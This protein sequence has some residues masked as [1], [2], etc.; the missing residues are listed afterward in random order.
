MR[1]FHFNHSGLLCWVA[2]WFQLY[3]LCCKLQRC[4]GQTPCSLEHYLVYPCICGSRFWSLTFRCRTFQF[5]IL[6]ACRL[7]P[8]FPVS[9]FQRSNTITNNV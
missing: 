2:H 5:C 4:T 6:Y 9:H 7:V 8:Y 1:A 3:E